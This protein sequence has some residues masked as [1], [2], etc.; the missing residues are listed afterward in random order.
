MLLDVSSSPEKKKKIKQTFNFN[1]IDD[2]IASCNIYT[3]VFPVKG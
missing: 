1:L 2:F 3:K